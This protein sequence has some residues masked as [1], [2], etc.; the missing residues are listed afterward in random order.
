MKK[1]LVGLLT[2][3]S[4][5]S[6]A[7]NFSYKIEG[8]VSTIKKF[9]LHNKILDLSK[10]SEKFSCE[11]SV[12]LFVTND[13]INVF[14][15]ASDSNKINLNISFTDDYTGKEVYSRMFNST[16]GVR[17]TLLTGRQEEIKIIESFIWE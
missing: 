15:M 4:I 13:K 11:G 9:V 2:M 5:T 10:C 3:C 14:L 16:L 6:F 7:A 8:D 12:E 17:R 1:L